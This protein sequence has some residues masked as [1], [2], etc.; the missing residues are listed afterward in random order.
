MER[1]NFLKLISLTG[2]ALP[3][4]NSFTGATKEI[5]QQ[6]QKLV[7]GVGGAGFSIL[8]IL[9][10]LPTFHLAGCQTIA[11]D[12]G[13][14][15]NLRFHKL[16]ASEKI[17]LGKRP[18]T[19]LSD[20]DVRTIQRV[21]LRE[22]TT[23]EIAPVLPMLNNAAAVILIAGIGGAAGS[24]IGPS[25]VKASVEI[26]IPTLGIWIQ[27]FKFENNRTD[28]F[29]WLVNQG[30][31]FKSS[32]YLPANDRIAER[33]GISSISLRNAYDLINKVVIE[34]Q[35]MP[36]ITQSEKLTRYC[37]YP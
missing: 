3:I 29:G 24:W 22:E 15:H 13:D 2:L 5:P 16:P 27:P 8:E 32:C 11:I 23:A 1:R 25:L 21:L 31:L 20:A 18:F 12:W 14:S 7:I 10:T 9:R 35:V 26:G 30:V 6:K 36:S 37:T 17:P 4:G 28:L 34:E 33:L 19:G